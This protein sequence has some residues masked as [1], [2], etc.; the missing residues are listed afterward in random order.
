MASPLHIISLGA[1]V[2]SSAMALMATAG[3]IG[4]M[5]DAAIFADTQAEPAACVFCPYHNDREWLRLKNEEPIEFARAVA[6]EA[7]LRPVVAAAT[8]LRATDAFLHRS[9]RPLAEVDFGTPDTPQADLFGNEC[10][11]MCGV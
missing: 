4:P 9:M 11:G 3:E 1:G 8:S 5:P 10:E 6:F 2:Q 7:R